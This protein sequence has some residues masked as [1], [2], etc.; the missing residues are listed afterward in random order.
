MAGRRREVGRLERKLAL[1][2]KSVSNRKW[3]G[4]PPSPS[5]SFA[6]GFYD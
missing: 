6:F 4:V 5:E 3:A 2:N 1:G